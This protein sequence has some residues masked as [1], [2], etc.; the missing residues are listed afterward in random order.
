MTTEDDA[1][2][3]R[4]RKTAHTACFEAFERHQRAKTREELS[5]GLL[6]VYFAATIYGRLARVLLDG[7]DTSRDLLLADAGADREAR[8]EI[9]REARQAAEEQLLGV[10]IEP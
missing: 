6:D 8:L 3:E 7:A 4:F 2:L 1:R 9:F 5:Q 10:S